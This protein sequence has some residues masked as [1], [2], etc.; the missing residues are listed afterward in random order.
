MVAGGYSWRGMHG[1]GDAFGRRALYRSEVLI[2]VAAVIDW[3]AC[4]AVERDP[5]HVSGVWVFRG[6]RVPVTALFEHLKDGARSSEFVEWFPGVA[7]AQVRAV[8]DVVLHGV[9]VPQIVR[10]GPPPRIPVAPLHEILEDLDESRADR[11]E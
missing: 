8:L 1:F 4:S 7:I 11:C 3:S 9:D 5:E 10:G 6:T 2:G